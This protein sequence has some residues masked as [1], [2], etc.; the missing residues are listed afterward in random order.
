MSK[1]RHNN[2]EPILDGLEALCIVALA[3]D[4]SGAEIFYSFA[5]D[6]LNS[7]GGPLFSHDTRNFY[8]RDRRSKKLLLEVPKHSTKLFGEV[9]RDHV[10]LCVRGGSTP[11]VSPGVIDAA[12]QRHRLAANRRRLAQQRYER[13]HVA[14]RRREA[15]IAKVLDD[16]LRFRRRVENSANWLNEQLSS[17]WRHQDSLNVHDYRSLHMFYQWRAG[18][19]CPVVNGHETERYAVR[20]S[21]AANAGDKPLKGAKRQLSRKCI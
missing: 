11:L 5:V 17:P 19:P 8:V 14:T 20:A 21:G 1:T 9:L 2:I 10:V 18:V 12:I 16:R 7:F 4:G 13:N 3:S 15:E 6:F